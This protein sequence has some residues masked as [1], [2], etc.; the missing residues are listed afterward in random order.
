LNYCDLSEVN[1]KKKEK[2]TKLKYPNIEEK[3]EIVPF[4]CRHHIEV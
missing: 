1:K 3:K 2:K 4:Y